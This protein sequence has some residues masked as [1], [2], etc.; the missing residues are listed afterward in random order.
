MRS[1]LA[2]LGL[3]ATAACA[4]PPPPSSAAAAPSPPPIAYAPAPLVWLFAPLAAPSP[5]RLALSNFSFAGARV[6]TL[7]TP[8]A[9]CVARPGTTA[10]DFVLPLNGTRIIEAAA[11]SDV[12]WRRAVAP[13]TAPAAATGWTPWNREFLSSGRSIDAQL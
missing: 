12:C 6:E 4:W 10:V 7:I 8:Y 9:D 5:A 11:G 2:V 1:L 13:G 3:L